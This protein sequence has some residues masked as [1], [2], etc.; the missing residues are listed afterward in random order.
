M[1]SVCD[2]DIPVRLQSIDALAASYRN[3][4][5]LLRAN[6]LETVQSQAKLAEVK[7]KLRDTED[8]LVKAL[9]VKTRRE[10]KRM[11]LKDVIAYVKG[12]VEDLKTSVLKQR[13]RIEECAT[14]VSQH[15]LVLA[16]TEEKSNKGTE[17]KDETQEAISWYNRILGF[18]V[19]GGH[20]VKFTFK[21]INVNNPN[22][23]YF[24]TIRH[25][26]DTYTL[27][28]CEPSLKD[29]ED[30]VHELNKTN[31]LFKF[32]RTMRKKFQEAVAQGSLSITANEH[33]ESAF[34]SASAPVLSI[35]TIRSYCPTK[36]N[37]YQDEFTGGNTYLRKQHYRRSVKSAI[38]SPASA[39]S[40]CQTPQLKKDGYGLALR[41]IWAFASLEL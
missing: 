19:E 7:A 31:G 8:E 32:I 35:S 37:D 22:E 21:N 29:T 33:Q 41:L 15:R 40:V 36:G 18:H 23:E 24:F 4:L 14:I 12:R 28:N 5:Q 26:D 38:Q 30:L 2:A 10:A 39:S 1:T 9:A 20:G 13:I 6:T 16:A 34:M 27:L 25:E 11:T 17:Q 3:S